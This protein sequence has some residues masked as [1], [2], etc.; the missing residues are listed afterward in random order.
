MTR[1]RLLLYA[2]FLTACIC[3][4][5]GVAAM[6]PAKLGVSQANLG[7]VEIGMT[8]AEVETI[9]GKHGEVA[10]FHGFEWVGDDGDAWV[11][12][13]E[14][15]RVTE[16]RWHEFPDERTLSERLLDCLPWRTKTI[17]RVNKTGH[18]TRDLSA[19]SA[20]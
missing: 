18:F 13:D 12:F 20:D 17:R 8:L 3:L 16:K 5:L 1:K 7:R 15:S 14:D 19:G 4:P 2:A 11:F 9:L 6:L 10:K